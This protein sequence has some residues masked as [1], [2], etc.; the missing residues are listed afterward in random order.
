MRTIIVPVDASDCSDRVIQEI[1]KLSKQG[2]PAD[3]HLVNVQP[4]IFTESALMFTDASKVDTYYYDQSGRALTFAEKALKSAGLAFTSHRL[5]G[6]VAE[7]IV[8]KAR[9][10]NADGIVMGT[11][12]HGKLTGMLLGSVS[13]KVLHLAPMPVT[14]VRGEPPIDFGGRL[15]AT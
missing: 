7:T 8:A 10:L 9:E 12:G 2:S 3:L 13:N 11:H 1:V 5:V 4:R 15:S 14:L 6:P